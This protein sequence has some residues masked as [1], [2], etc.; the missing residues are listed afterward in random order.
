APCRHT[1]RNLRAIPDELR[2]SENDGEDPMTQ[3]SE[4]GGTTRRTLLF[5]AGAAALLAGIGI[6]PRL[7]ARAA[8]TNLGT[9]GHVAIEAFDAAGRSLGAS[10]VE[11]VVKT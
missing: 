7:S 11:K 1:G 4:T 2:N 3:N 6:L 9:P 5:T 10:T 8:T